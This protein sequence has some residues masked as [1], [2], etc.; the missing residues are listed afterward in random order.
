MLR[1]L[2]AHVLDCEIVRHEKRLAAFCAT[3]VQV[4]NV[5]ANIQTVPNAFAVIG[6]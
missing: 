3:R 1:V 4:C 6:W 2:L 5:P